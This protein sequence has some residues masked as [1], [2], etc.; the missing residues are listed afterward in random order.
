MDSSVWTCEAC[1]KMC[2][3]KINSNKSQSCKPCQ[4][5]R[6]VYCV[7]VAVLQRCIILQVDFSV[8]PRL[9]SFLY[10]RR[11][12]HLS[13]FFYS[14]HLACFYL[15]LKTEKL[16]L[17]LN[18]FTLSTNHSSHRFFLSASGVHGDGTEN[19][20]QKEGKAWKQENSEYNFLLPENTHFL[21]HFTLN[22]L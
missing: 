4:C 22:F 12:E 7:A 19:V 20:W 1:T 21:I 2:N 3:N 14:F 16:E 18:L 13:S 6:Y 5:N 11:S 17:L 8:F 10:T 9:F 15:N